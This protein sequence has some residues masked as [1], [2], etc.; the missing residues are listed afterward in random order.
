MRLRTHF[1][2]EYYLSVEIVWI[3][4]ISVLLLSVNRA[5]PVALLSTGS[6]GVIT[7]IVWIARGYTAGC[8]LEQWV[9]IAIF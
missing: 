5:G 1:G 7:F 9:Y 2:P 8:D 6:L 3:R 4:S